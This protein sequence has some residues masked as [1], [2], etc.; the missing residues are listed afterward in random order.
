M[1]KE[2]KDEQEEKEEEPRKEGGKRSRHQEL[3]M[4]G[5]INFI[6]TKTVTTEFLSHPTPSPTHISTLNYALRRPL[7]PRN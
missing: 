2:K 6:V 5:G 4:C 3:L 7:T 1:D